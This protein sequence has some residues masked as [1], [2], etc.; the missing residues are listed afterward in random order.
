MPDELFGPLAQRAD[1]ELAEAFG[2]PLEQIAKKRRDL[3]GI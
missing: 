3:A 2:I 1:Q